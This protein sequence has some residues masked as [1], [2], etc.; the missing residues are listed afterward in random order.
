MKKFSELQ[1]SIPIKGPYKAPIEVNYINKKFIDR[2]EKELPVFP[3]KN[4]R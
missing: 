2:W 3:S 4:S 1:R